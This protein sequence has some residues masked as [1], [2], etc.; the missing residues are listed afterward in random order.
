M[1][2]TTWNKTSHWFK[3]ICIILHLNT[4]KTRRS[5]LNR[6][7]MLKSLIEALVIVGDVS[8]LFH[9]QPDYLLT[10]TTNWRGVH[11]A[12]FVAWK[13]YELLNDKQSGFYLNH[14]IIVEHVHG[15]N[16]AIHK[17]LFLSSYFYFLSCV[18]TKNHTQNDGQTDW[19]LQYTMAKIIANKNKSVKTVVKTAR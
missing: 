17:W 19:Y 2:E 13:C 6:L 15:S 1:T 9:L 4:I 7:S 18:I 3:I 12:A 8:F 16:F 11:T 14:T 5:M 10:I